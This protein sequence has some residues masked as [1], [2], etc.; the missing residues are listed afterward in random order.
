MS[1]LYGRAIGKNLKNTLGLGS[2]VKSM[3]NCLYQVFVRLQT[4]NGVAR[5]SHVYILES[6]S[7]YSSTRNLD[8][9][10]L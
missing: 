4:G 6:R 2:R 7:A 1:Y 8:Q 9:N 5:V 10:E 3:T